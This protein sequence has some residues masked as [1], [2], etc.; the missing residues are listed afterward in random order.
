MSEEVKDCCPEPCPCPKPKALYAI[1][2]T[3]ALLN[4][5]LVIVKVIKGIE[6]GLSIDKLI[7][8]GASIIAQLPALAKAGLEAWSSISGSW[9]EFSNMNAADFSDF[10]DALKPLLVEIYSYVKKEDGVKL[11]EEAISAAE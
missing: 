7:A 9:S 10:L 4:F 11:L 6:W 8:A 5:M 3:K 1:P 2:K